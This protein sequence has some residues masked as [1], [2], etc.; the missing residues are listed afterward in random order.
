MGNPVG[1]IFLMGISMKWYCPSSEKTTP[2]RAQ[3][4]NA[5]TRFAR[6]GA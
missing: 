2:V 6:A 3:R 4:A 5:G 1:R